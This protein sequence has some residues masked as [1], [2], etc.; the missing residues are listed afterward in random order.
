[1]ETI[2]GLS[3]EEVKAALR[4]TQTLADLQIGR[5]K[6]LDETGFSNADISLGQ[7]LIAILEHDIGNKDYQEVL[8]MLLTKYRR[9]AMPLMG[10]EE[11]HRFIS[12]AFDT[13]SSERGNQ[14][15]QSSRAFLSSLP[16]AQAAV[17]ITFALNSKNEDCYQFRWKGYSA[18]I[19][20][21]LK[22][23]GAKW[24]KIAGKGY[25]YC[26]PNRLGFCLDALKEIGTKYITD[27][28]EA[29]ATKVTVQ[30]SKDFEIIAIGD[31]GVEIS[32]PYSSAKVAIFQ[33]MEKKGRI[34]D[35]FSK[36]WTVKFTHLQV[37]IDAWKSNNF[38]VKPFEELIR[39]F[40]DKIANQQIASN[41]APVE[42]AP[43][44]DGYE[45]TFSRMLLPPKPYQ[46]EGMD[47]MLKASVVIN[48]DAPG[49]GKTVQALMAIEH[50]RLTQVNKSALIVTIAASKLNWEDDIKKFFGE[51]D[52]LIV[53]AQRK[54]TPE[55]I[56]TAHLRGAYVIINYDVLKKYFDVLISREWGFIVYDEA[57]S[58]KNYTAKRTELSMGKDERPEYKFKGKTIPAQAYVPGIL[59]MSKHVF[60]LSGTLLANRPKDLYNVLHVAKY[61]KAKSFRSF[62]KRFCNGHET[63]FGYDAMGASNIE[64][65][66][67]DIKKLM[68]RRTKEEVF[69]DFPEKRRQWQRAEID[70]AE[71]NLEMR[72]YKSQIKTQEQFQKMR[73]AIIATAMRLVAKGKMPSTIELARTALEAGE[74]V[75]IFT[76]YNEPLDLAVA[77]LAEYNPGVIRGGQNEIERFAVQK[78]FQ[79]PNGDCKV[80]IA[81][82]KA[83][84]MAITL[85]EAS[86]VFM[87]DLGYLPFVLNQAEDRAWRLGVKHM[88]LIHYVLAYGTVDEFLGNLMKGKLDVIGTFEGREEESVLNEFMRHVGKTEFNIGAV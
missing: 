88:V 11:Y 18:T 42:L 55:A 21:S 20:N 82:M 49:V 40:A 73:L 85:T 60:F 46:I 72:K 33:T 69:A 13:L 58:V 32:F 86:H 38:D 61:P 7:R 37:V 83:G 39:M 16:K 15:R 17:T 26:F 77:E 63:N 81:N 4:A 43:N 22:E 25:A 57:T 5:E 75:I 19:Y 44:F 64:E 1:M 71:Y 24:D 76:N 47:F 65:L 14:L 53:S 12:I 79:D 62:A 34:Y 29:Q 30:G 52:I 28:D 78:H 66:R 10:P 50:L 70:M 31:E 59:H 8:A 74:K 41:S 23:A 27:F 67:D 45:A 87:N 54:T 68:I 36:R 9:Q 84:A 48:G 56:K 6:V 2:T 51:R 3:Q 80:I 35:S